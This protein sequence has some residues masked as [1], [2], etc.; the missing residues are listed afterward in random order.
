MQYFI[1]GWG[2]FNVPPEDVSYFPSSPQLSDASRGK[3]GNL[4]TLPISQPT[5]LHST[6]PG[7]EEM[8]P[9]WMVRGVEDQGYTTEKPNYEP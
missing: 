1:T 8:T 4:V 3:V 9:L 2:T 5:G 7:G 6:S